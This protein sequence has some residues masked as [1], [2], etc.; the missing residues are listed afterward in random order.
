VG[1]SVAVP[2]RARKTSDDRHANIASQMS[3]IIA[4]I[5]ERECFTSVPVRLC[6]RGLFND[7]AR[8]G[9]ETVLRVRPGR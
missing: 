3:A 6:G 2:P 1:V 7:S 8:L 5:L 9:N 4:K